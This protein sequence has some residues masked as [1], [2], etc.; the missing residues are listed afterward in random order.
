MIFILRRYRSVVVMPN[1]KVLT[2]KTFAMTEV[3]FVIS[4]VELKAF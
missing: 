1:V 2:Q 3:I 4:Y